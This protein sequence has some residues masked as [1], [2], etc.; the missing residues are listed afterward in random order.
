MEGKPTMTP[1]G[2]S[3]FESL[4]LLPSSC[5]WRLRSFASPFRVGSWFSWSPGSEP[6]WCWGVRHFP[7]EGLGSRFMGQ[8]ETTTNPAAP[9]EYSRSL[10]TEPGLQQAQNT[11]KTN[12]QTLANHSRLVGHFQTPLLLF[13]SS[14]HRSAQHAPGP[15][16]FVR[17]KRGPQGTGRRWEEVCP[18]TFVVE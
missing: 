15:E 18:K 13:S 6:S 8:G 10:F 5:F 4:Q 17:R 11:K 7:S 12:L 3:S 2:L 14:L 9:W 16:S 1:K